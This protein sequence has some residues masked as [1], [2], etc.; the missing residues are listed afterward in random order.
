MKKLICLKQTWVD[1]KGL[2]RSQV[3]EAKGDLFQESI[4]AFKEQMGDLWKTKQ[5]KILKE[6]SAT[7]DVLIEYADAIDEQMWSALRAEVV[8]ET[9]D[10]MIP[11]DLL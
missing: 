10:S 7:N 9:I 5:F 11:K 4:L 8:V 3:S 6:V 1:P 2:K